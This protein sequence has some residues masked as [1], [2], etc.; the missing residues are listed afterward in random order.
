MVNREKEI[1][2]QVRIRTQQLAASEARNKMLVDN[3]AN[4]V[5]SIASDHTIDSFNPAAES[6]FGYPAKDII[7]S[8]IHS[9][10]QNTDD[11]ELALLPSAE[12]S[13][14][15]IRKD[16]SKFPLKLSLGLNQINNQDALVAILSDDTKR[17]EAERLLIQS[18]EAAEEANQQ[19][20]VFLNMMSHELRTPLTVILGYIPLLQNPATLPSPDLV[21]QIADDISISGNHLMA[22]IDDLLDIS[23]IESGK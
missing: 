5:I 1:S 10:V 19:K 4:G 12:I 11:T 17:Q 21:K 18:K 9:L 22:L 13:L 7:G 23:K 3:A 6:I 14:I 15:G 16:N 20:S 8:S 2:Q